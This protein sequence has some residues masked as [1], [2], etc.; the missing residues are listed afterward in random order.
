MTQLQ[1]RILKLCPQRARWLVQFCLT[2]RGQSSPAI[3]AVFA[4][5]RI[6]TGPLDEFHLK[7]FRCHMSVNFTIRELRDLERFCLDQAEQSATPDGRTALRILADNYA[8]VAA[9]LAASSG[10]A[11]PPINRPG[12]TTRT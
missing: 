2:Y 11:R 5:S 12:R 6:P 8:A 9:S 10:R 7:R 3:Q 4:A 1:V